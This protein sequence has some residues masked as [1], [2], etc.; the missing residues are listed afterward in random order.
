MKWVKMST[1]PILLKIIIQ[2]YVNVLKYMMTR[3]S[4]LW[5]GHVLDKV[6]L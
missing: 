5:H 6:S 2:V 3:N 4:H 1:Y